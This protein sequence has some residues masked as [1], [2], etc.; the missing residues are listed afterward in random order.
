MKLLFDQNLSFKLVRKLSE[1]FANS[2]H[3]SDLRMS[4][5]SD[6]DIWEYCKNE[7]YSII[8]NYSD[9][10]DISN[11]HG[12]PPK[13]IWLRFGNLS[14][15]DLSNK[16]KENFLSIKHFLENKDNAFLEVN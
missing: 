12:F 2:R 10:I 16:I 14:T 11:L 3:V 1:L 5:S 9:F 13:I 8:T 6:Y 15:E 7:N 4:S